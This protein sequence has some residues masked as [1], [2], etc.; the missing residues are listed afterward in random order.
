ME[1]IL[2]NI[3]DKKGFLPYIVEN[4]LIGTVGI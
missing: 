1:Y 2:K 4:I 3:R